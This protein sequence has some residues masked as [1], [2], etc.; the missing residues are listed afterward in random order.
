[1]A[2][3]QR[4]SLF[5]FPPMRLLFLLF[6]SSFLAIKGGAQPTFDPVYQPIR[7]G[8][9]VQ[10]KNFYLLSLMLEIPEIRETLARDETLSAIASE[11]RSELVPDTLLSR[12]RVDLNCYT[13]AYFKLLENEEEIGQRLV[14]LVDIEPVVQTLID[15][16]M[17]PS[18][19]FNRFA[20]LSDKEMLR[21]AWLA[22]CAGMKNIVEVYSL[23]KKGRYPDI[24]SLWY[25][26]DLDHGYWPRMMASVA[27]GV[28][29]DADA[30]Q[31]P[32]EPLLHYAMTLLKVNYRDE[33][34]RHE[35]MEWGENAKALAY[36]PE[37]DWDQ[38]PYATLLQP[39]HGPEK[40]G[41][42]LSPL[43]FMRVKLV[44]ERYHQGWAPLII[45]SGGYVHPYQ[46]PYAEAT[47]MKKVL[48]EEYGVPERAI[49]IEPHARH[50]TTNF[51]NAARLMYQYGI[52]TDKPSVCTTTFDQA[53]YIVDPKYKFDERNL[54]ELGYLPYKD[55]KKFSRND[56]EFKPV[57]T[58]LHLD[59]TD[60]LD[61]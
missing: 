37:I 32:F 40:K 16:H 34:G 15:D 45:L 56:I 50:T 18:G 9:Y 13:E 52:P 24:D 22:A 43:G 49:L 61:P 47:E 23:G 2:A 12:C 48:I 26:M 31:L 60:P 5:I 55:L 54:N 3:G 44:A 11:I 46:T 30:K 20:E 35:P 1:M 19:R 10:D 39:G 27:L 28:A 33:A 14:E 8:S 25:P 57:I 6:F 4:A 17:R 51:R 29:D 38:Y 53:I 41:I 36:I 59:A 21:R 42:P 7:S 58:S